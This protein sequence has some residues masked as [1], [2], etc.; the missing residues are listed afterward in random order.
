M[1]LAQ[2]VR[3]RSGQDYDLVPLEKGS[4]WIDLALGEFPLFVK[5]NHAVFLCPGGESS[6]LL[7]DTRFTVLGVIEKES[8]YELYR[9]DGKTAAPSLGSGLTEIK[10]VP[11]TKLKRSIEC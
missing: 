4:H 2:A 6:E 9:D 3:F 11:D 5:K 10:L 1:S 7:D 8:V